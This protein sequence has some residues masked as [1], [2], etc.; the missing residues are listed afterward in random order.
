M[1]TLTKNDNFKS[2]FL[3]FKKI[4][5]LKFYIIIFLYF[6]RQFFYNNLKRK[7]IIKI[8]NLGDSIVTKYGSDKTNFVGGGQII[9][10]HL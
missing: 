9:Y 1:K 10:I 7:K 8:H 5:F 3:N 6:L 4:F 2:F